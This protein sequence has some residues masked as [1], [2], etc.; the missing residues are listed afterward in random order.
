MS[1]ITPEQQALEWQRLIE[2]F[3][4]E[5]TARVKELTGTHQ[6]ELAV[7]FYEQMLEDHDA[8]EFLSHDQVKNR[9]EH[10]MREWIGSLFPESPDRERLLALIAQQKKI[11]EIHAR[12]NIPV[13]LVLRGARHLKNRYTALLHQQGLDDNDRLG[14]IRLVTQVIDLAM[15]IMCGAYSNAHD[16]HSRQ[17]EG[18][19]LFSVMQNIGN[20][21]ERQ[22]AA[23]LDWENQVMFALA[24]AHGAVQLA[25]L[26]MSEFGLW[27]QHKGAYAFEGTSEAVRILE[28]MEHIDSALLPTFT[29]LATEGGERFG[30][31]RDLREQTKLI[32]F[33]LDNLFSEMH[34][35]EGGRD[36]LTRMLNR[37]FLSVVM[38]KEVA[39]AQHSGRAFAA[40]LIDIDHFKSINDSLGHEAGDHVLQQVATLLSNNCRGGD[41]VFRLGGEEFLVVL[42]D[43][44]A[45]SA[46]GVAEKLRR[47]IEQERFQL[48]GNQTLQLSVSIGLALHDGHPDYQHT[49]RRA[50]EAL[51]AA[52]HGG[53]NR[54]VVAKAR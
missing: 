19:R 33:H 42:V 12:I 36:A 45:N 35:L 46:L 40:L 51:Y 1:S 43:I 20:E 9:L 50:D 10:S 48:P 37:K 34:E 32:L 24:S 29:D 23:L 27:F 21:R 14:A 38:G 13:H 28:S 6:A 18:Y 44:N 26:S 11:G 47:Q 16:R 3:P 39:Y 25:K 49:L 54:V 53:R 17:E 7:F 5:V 31:L 4:P 52:K 8:R 41:Y 22:R 2:Q 30:R 15:E